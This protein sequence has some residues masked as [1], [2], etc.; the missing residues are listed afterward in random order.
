MTVF[1]R[2]YCPAE[3]H[4]SDDNFCLNI[5][6]AFSNMSQ[7]AA[8]ALRNDVVVNGFFA[9]LKGGVGF[10][11]Y[12]L[13]PVEQVVSLYC[14][15]VAGLSRDA[16]CFLLKLCATGFTAMGIAEV[17]YGRADR[18]SRDHRY[19]GDPAV[20]SNGLLPTVTFRFASFFLGI[21]SVLSLMSIPYGPI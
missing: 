18:G 9:A 21:H 20:T 3:G 7:V 6:R 5:A 10:G 8:N 11:D 19:A 12:A 1:I 14:H 2:R 4:D 15:F 13:R 17:H 16:A